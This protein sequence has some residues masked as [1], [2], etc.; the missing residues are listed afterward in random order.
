MLKDIEIE[1][2]I[3]FNDEEG[4]LACR[5][6]IR[7]LEINRFNEIKKDHFDKFY[8]VLRSCMCYETF[9][10]KAVYSD[11]EFIQIYEKIY[12]KPKPK[13]VSNNDLTNKEINAKLI[14]NNEE[15][16]SKIQL[17]SVLKL[18][19]AKEIPCDAFNNHDLYSDAYELKE[20]TFIDMCEHSL[21]RDEYQE[22]YNLIHNDLLPNAES[23]D[24]RCPMSQ[25]G[26]NYFERKFEYIFGKCTANKSLKI[27]HSVSSLVRNDLSNCLSFKLDYL[28]SDASNKA[29]ILDLPFDI[30]YAI[31]DRLD[32]MSIYCLSMTCRV[33]LN[34]F[35]FLP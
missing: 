29:N 30:L 21:R 24:F 5:A 16:L 33:I 14:E 11:P 12:F 8:A 28:N 15:I 2:C 9:I 25:Y 31:I 13:V 6:R 32:S 7:N 22:H 3:I 20:M 17:D 4:C 26:C 34:F 1:N 18:N 27:E 10:E 23:I 35:F 19:L